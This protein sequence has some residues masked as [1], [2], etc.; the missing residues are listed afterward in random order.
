MGSADFP[1][2]SK[3]KNTEHYGI[4]QNRGRFQSCCG[5]ESPR[6]GKIFGTLPIFCTVSAVPSGLVPANDRVPNVETLGYYR[7]SLRDEQ[8]FWSCPRLKALGAEAFAA[9]ATGGGIRIRD[10]EAAIL[11]GVAIVQ[12]AAGHVKGAF[13]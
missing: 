3:V 4:S 2:R 12:F 8:V 1:V 9:G 6:S 13:R 7:P 5:L 11:E 10:F